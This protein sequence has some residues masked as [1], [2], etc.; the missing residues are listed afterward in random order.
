MFYVFTNHCLVT[1]PNSVLRLHPYWLATVSQLTHSTFDS[2]LMTD[3]L[4]PLVPIIWPR[5]GPHGK[6]RQLH[7]KHCIIVVVYRLLRSNGSLFTDVIT[8]L[9]CRCLATAVF[10]GFMSQYI[11]CGNSNVNDAFFILVSTWWETYWNVFHLSTS[12][13]FTWG[14][15]QEQWIW[16]LNWERHK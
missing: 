12:E 9:V 16:T 15:F 1:D 7:R 13:T 2:Q 11:H 5:V 6:R 3:W 10:S 14:F 4:V 8:C